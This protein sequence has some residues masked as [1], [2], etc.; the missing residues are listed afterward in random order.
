MA[1]G[2][3]VR[4]RMYNMGFGD[5]FLMRLPTADGDRKVLIDCGKHFLSTCRPPL[6]ETVPQVQADITDPDGKKRIDVLIVTHRHQDHV[7]GFEYEGWDDV[8]AGEVWMPWTEDPDDPVARRICKTQSARALQLGL[9]IEAL[10]MNNEAKAELLGYAGNNLTNA[11]AMNLLHHGFQGTPRRRFL[12]EANASG[13]LETE[14]LPGV[15]VQVLGPSRSEKVIRDMD[16][17]AGER[18]LQALLASMTAAQP[19]AS[20]FSKRHVLINRRAYRAWFQA[21]ARRARFGAQK[22]SD[23]LAEF[24]EQSQKHF[25]QWSENPQAEL[26]AALE[27]SVNGTSLV[28]RFQVGNAVLLFPGDAQWGTWNEMLEHETDT[29]SLEKVVFYKVGHHGS[30]NATPRSFVENFLSKATHAMVPTDNVKRWPMI[31]RKQ[32]L[33]ALTQKEVCFVR[34]DQAAPTGDPECFHRETDGNGDTKWVD[35]SLPC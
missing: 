26:A 18:F 32:L 29:R 4:I 19:P 14:H 34:S 10:A 5:C 31:P 12:P 1:G 8:E 2:K 7:S 17:P 30:H 3:S 21:H 25:R 15:K 22:R 16:P 33:E 23:P 35:F 28:L 13:P 6:R 11:A 24:S 27:K 9:G 20:P